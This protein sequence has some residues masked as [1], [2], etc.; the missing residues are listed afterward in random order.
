MTG[1]RPLED[2]RVVELSGIGPSRY[3]GMLLAELGADVVLVTRPG[4]APKRADSVVGRGRRTV[5]ADLKS[6]QGR[7]H[8]LRLIDEADLF[9][10]PYRPGVAERLGI[11]PDVCLARNRRLV[12]GRITGWGQD[13]PLAATAGHD[14]NYIAITGVLHAVGR[15]GGPP[16]PPLNLVGDFGGGTM[17]L[18]L[19][20]LA[21]L[22]QRD[23]TGV[24]SVIDTSIVDGTLSLAGFI[25][26]LRNEGQWSDDRG[27]NLLDTG[28][29]YY[30]VYQTADDNWVAVGA[31]EPQFFA[32][33]MRLLTI[34]DAPTQNDREQWPRL[35]ALIGA[36]VRQ[37]TRDEWMR[38][39]EGTDACVAPVL[40]FAEAARHPHIV[41]RR[42]LTES[43]GQLFPAAAPR[44][45]AAE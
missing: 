36:A 28:A 7:E 27:T 4:E 43:G 3:T 29:P 34:D 33:L 41:A 35:R 21:A 17:F 25:L 39:F 20:M 45:T 15:A 9:I 5:T 23:I 30:D 42:A 2:I 13:G 8:V 14:I 37:R 10:E 22:H 44:I 40:T 24:G 26:G 1:R 12:Y 16:Q 18:L 31:I 11:G 6:E 32:E 38:V 19:G